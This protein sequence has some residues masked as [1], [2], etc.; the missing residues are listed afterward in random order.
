MTDYYE[1]DDRWKDYEITSREEYVSNVV[2]KGVFH[3]DV[4]EDVIK[5][6]E[7]VEYLM[8]HAW[9]FWSFWDEAFAKCLFILEMAV[10]I[11]AKQLGIEIERS[12]KA[13]NKRVM[14]LAELIDE[15][16]DAPHYDMLKANLHRAR[17]LRNTIAHPTEHG[18]MGPA[19][20]NRN[21]RHFIINLNRLFKEE[22][23]FIEQ[24]DLREKIRKVFASW[25]NQPVAFEAIGSQ[26][27]LYSSIQTMEV[28]EKHLMVSLIPVL[29]IPQQGDRIDQPMV[30]SFIVRNVQ[31]KDGKVFGTSM[32]GTKLVMYSTSNETHLNATDESKKYLVENYS[33]EE[34]KAGEVLNA[35][36]APWQLVDLEY[37]YLQY[38]SN[39]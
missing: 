1:M 28:F 16:Y 36:I 27:G 14:R 9:Y 18:I 6:F 29:K 20:L 39:N 35:T 30:A 32:D 37:E 33:S 38:L 23:W 34:I 13:G 12:T 8:A 10:K 31:T 4:P 26:G 3:S 25:E 22:R 24:R 19:G 15:M 2:I 7:T 5:E 17:K 21:I 11:R